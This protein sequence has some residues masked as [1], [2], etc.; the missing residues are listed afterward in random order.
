MR[1]EQVIHGR[2]A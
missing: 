2:S 1:S